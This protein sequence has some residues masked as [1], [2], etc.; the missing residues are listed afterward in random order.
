MKTTIAGQRGLPPG[1]TD[2]VVDVEQAELSESFGLSG[3]FLVRCFNSNP[4]PVHLKRLTEYLH[5]LGP[6]D[7]LVLQTGK[8]VVLNPMLAF[9]CVAKT[10]VVHDQV[11][12]ILSDNQ[13]AVIPLDDTFFQNRDDPR[14]VD[15]GDPGFLSG[16]ERPVRQYS[17]GFRAAILW[18]RTASRAVG[19][20]LAQ[21][22]VSRNLRTSQDWQ[23]VARLPT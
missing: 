6:Q 11:M 12:R 4:R 1:I 22:S 3:S 9:I 19:R 15:P 21:R 8:R 14:A 10:N 5:S 18:S 20:C 13:A 23:D 7:E 17:A 2:I 16:Q